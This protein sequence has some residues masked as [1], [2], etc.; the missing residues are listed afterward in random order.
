MV[1]VRSVH[2]GM[3]PRNRDVEVRENSWT[4]LIPG[5]SLML[6]TFILLHSAIRHGRANSYKISSCQRGTCSIFWCEAGAEKSLNT[7]LEFWRVVKSKE[8]YRSRAD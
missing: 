5:A 6:G 4:C 1:E 3:E 2:D 7:L 8:S